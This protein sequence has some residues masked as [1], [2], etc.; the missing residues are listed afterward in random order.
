M[1]SDHSESATEL[2]SKVAP[3]VA[4]SSLSFFGVSLPELVQLV[5]FIYVLVMIVDKIYVI[6]LRHYDKKKED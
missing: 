5:T 4:I 3:P 6:A 1:I 2:L